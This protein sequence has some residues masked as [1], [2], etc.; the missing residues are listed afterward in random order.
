MQATS[1]HHHVTVVTADMTEHLEIVRP[2]VQHMHPDGAFGWL[3][4]LIDHPAPHHRFTVVAVESL[5]GG[6]VLWGCLAVM[7]LGSGQTT[8]H[9]GVGFNQQR[10]MEQETQTG[11]VAKRTSAGDALVA[12][13]VDLGGV[14]QKQIGAS[15]ALVGE[16]EGRRDKQS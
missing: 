11:T 5:L 16:N 1:P 12:A 9:L 15:P 13:E 2:P 14:A 7:N 8:N 6:L 10:R 3:A 4:G